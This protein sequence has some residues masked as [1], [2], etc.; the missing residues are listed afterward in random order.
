MEADYPDYG[1]SIKRLGRNDTY[2]F[3]DVPILVINRETDRQLSCDVVMSHEGEKH[4]ATFLFTKDQYFQM[5]LMFEPMDKVLDAFEELKHKKE[6][7]L[8]LLVAYRVNIEAVLGPSIVEE[9]EVINPFVVKKFS[10]E[11]AR[12]SDW[13][14]IF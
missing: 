11:N 14:S 12:E 8:K 13:A 4:W 9:L 3:F 1:S 6:K 2:T 7:R 5:L 10:S